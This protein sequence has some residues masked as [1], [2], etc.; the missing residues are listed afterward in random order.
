V[1]HDDAT[2]VARQPPRRFCSNVLAVLE[3]RLPRLIRVNQ[4]RRID[5]DDHLVAV[6]R[7]AGKWCS[8]AS[9]IIPRAS[10]CC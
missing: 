8:A 7:R 1:A 6:T 3:G 5:M 2:G 9:A 4:R 10:A